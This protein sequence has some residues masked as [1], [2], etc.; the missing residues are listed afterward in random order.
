MLLS[1]AVLGDMKDKSDFDLI[2]TRTNTTHI[3][4]DNGIWGISS[5]QLHVF[6]GSIDGQ[7][8]CL[9]SNS[10]VIYRIQGEREHYSK[11]IKFSLAKQRHEQMLMRFWL[12]SMT[13]FYL[14]IV[15]H[16]LCSKSLYVFGV[17]YSRCELM[18]WKEYY[19]NLE[20]ALNL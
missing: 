20:E 14:W 4:S 2:W 6:L 12:K 9:S 19:K 7:I 8:G 18:C 3:I 5:N 1:L 15:F 16:L 11:T 10:L 13:L 17:Q